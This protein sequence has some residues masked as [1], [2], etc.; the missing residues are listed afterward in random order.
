MGAVTGFERERSGRSVANVIGEFA[1]EGTV[2]VGREAG[3]YVGIGRRESADEEDGCSF[4][5]RNEFFCKK[6]KV[7]PNSELIELDNES[8]NQATEQ[9]QFSRD[10]GFDGSNNNF[11][12]EYCDSNL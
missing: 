6:S 7:T 11:N 8:S 3:G 1:E 10:V 9:Q 4:P 2:G 5:H 12:C